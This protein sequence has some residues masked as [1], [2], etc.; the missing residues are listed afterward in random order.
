[1]AAVRTSD[2]AAP[3][4]FDSP[5]PASKMAVSTLGADVEEEEQEED[6]LE[7]DDDENEEGVSEELD[8][9]LRAEWSTEEAE[10]DDYVEEDDE[11]SE[12][13]YV[14]APRAL[15][16][17]HKARGSAASTKSV[18]KVKAKVVPTSPEYDVLVE[19][20]SKAK[21][22]VVRAPVEEVEEMAL[23]KSIVIRPGASKKPKRFVPFCACEVG[24]CC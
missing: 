12:D 10:S 14:P 9:P 16:A 4:D 2:R 20:Q 11:A 17:G 23:D 13:D 15:T 5:L 8:V 21:K 24:A 3:G 18:A 6:D 7:E 19:I 1:M 22:T